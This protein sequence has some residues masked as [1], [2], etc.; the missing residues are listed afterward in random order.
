MHLTTIKAAQKL[1]GSCKKQKRKNQFEKQLVKEAETFLAKREQEK[2]KT[3]LQG[4]TEKVA[5]GDIVQRPPQFGA[6]FKKLKAKLDQ[7]KNADQ[8]RKFLFQ[9]MTGYS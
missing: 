1:T 8:S 9:E 3:V 5:F 2:E 7:K 6:H 4:S